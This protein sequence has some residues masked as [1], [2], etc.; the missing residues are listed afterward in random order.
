MLSFEFSGS[1]AGARLLSSCVPDDTKGFAIEVAG[2]RPGGRGTFLCFAKAKYP[3]ERRAG[4]VAR[5]RRY[6]ALLGSDGVWLNSLR[7]DNA[8][9]DPSAPALL[10]SS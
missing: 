9:P 7:S 3:K 8:S 6:A 4:F 5:L 10:A 2:S 1:C